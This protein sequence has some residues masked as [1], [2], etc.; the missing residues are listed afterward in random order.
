MNR[1][2]RFAIIF[3]AAFVVTAPAFAME[4]WPDSFSAYVAK[5]RKTVKTTG[6]ATL[7]AADLKKIGFMNV[8]VTA[9]VANVNDMEKKGFRCEK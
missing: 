9:V 6:R 4:D 8:N 7:A 3:V 1:T 5:A 2:L